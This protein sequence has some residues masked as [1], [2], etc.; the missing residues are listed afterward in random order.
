M[1]HD[2]VGRAG[3][4][5]SASDKLAMPAGRFGRSGSPGRVCVGPLR[6]LNVPLWYWTALAP[7]PSDP[8]ASAACHR[9]VAAMLDSRDPVELQ[10]ADMLIRHLDGGVR[11][12]LPREP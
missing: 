1:I 7:S 3:E 4:R 8:A 12:R 11:R 2:A 9:A 6:L 5:R 10:R